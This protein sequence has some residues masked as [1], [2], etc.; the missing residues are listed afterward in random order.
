[1]SKRLLVTFS[2]LTLILAGLCLADPELQIIEDAPELPNGTVS[3]TYYFRSG[4]CVALNKTA[5]NL[6]L[7]SS[8]IW[9]FLAADGTAIATYDVDSSEVRVH[10]TGYGFALLNEGLVVYSEDD[11]YFEGLTFS[12]NGP[13]TLLTGKGRET[14][15][16]EN[17]EY[18]KL[19]SELGGSIPEYIKEQIE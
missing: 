19:I 14:A 10:P 2:A 11:A 1:M 13:P 12:E 7:F 8:N 3:N 16:A 18:Y 6:G 4:Q 15:M 9:H 5:K 17:R